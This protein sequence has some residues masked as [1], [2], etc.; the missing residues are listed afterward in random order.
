MNQT[1]SAYASQNIGAGRQKR[2]LELRKGA[3]PGVMGWLRMKNQP[4]NKAKCRRRGY[5]VQL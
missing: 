3:K 4:W 1:M 5:A 2:A